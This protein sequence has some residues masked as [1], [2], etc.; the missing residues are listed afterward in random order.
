MKLGYDGAIC[1]VASDNQSQKDILTYYGWQK[2]WSF[3]SSKT[4][5]HV[6]LWA[7]ILHD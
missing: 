3:N 2:V 7:K 5:H 4:G 1:T 6:E